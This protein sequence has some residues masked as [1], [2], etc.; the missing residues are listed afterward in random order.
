MLCFVWLALKRDMDKRVWWTRNPAAIFEECWWL[1]LN[2]CVGRENI[3]SNTAIALA[4]TASREPSGGCFGFQGSLSLVFL[5][6]SPPSLPCVGLPATIIRG[7]LRGLGFWGAGVMRAWMRMQ[8]RVGG[9][10]CLETVIVLWYSIISMESLVSWFVCVSICV[11]MFLLCMWE[12]SERG[13]DIGVSSFIMFYWGR[14]S[15]WISTSPIW[16]DSLSPHHAQTCTHTHPS[17]HMC[18]YTHAYQIQIH[19]KKHLP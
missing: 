9:Y 14:V 8:R 7:Q 13:G 3:C 15:H 5:P 6:E 4:F 19:E 12:L 1:S 11:Y 10:P 2:S 16:I 18:A 17:L